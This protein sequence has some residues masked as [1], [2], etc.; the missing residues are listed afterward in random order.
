MA[1]SAPDDEANVEMVEH[2]GHKQLKRQINAFTCKILRET[3]LYTQE[4]IGEIMVGKVVLKTPE[5]GTR[6]I[7]SLIT[8]P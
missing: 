6:E 4:K 7:A 3:C 8:P 1:D 2:A 5:S